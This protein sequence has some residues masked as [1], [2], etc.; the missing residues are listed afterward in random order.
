MQW[1]EQNQLNQL[2]VSSM[3]TYLVKTAYYNDTTGIFV[4]TI[5]PQSYPT[6]F[7]V[8]GKVFSKPQIEEAILWYERN[9]KPP[10]DPTPPDPDTAAPVP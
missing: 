6:V 4:W 10:P 8:E 9:P 5:T 1:I 2:V 3:D 7:P